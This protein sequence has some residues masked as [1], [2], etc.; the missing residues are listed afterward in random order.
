MLSINFTSDTINIVE[1]KYAGSKVMV[2]K[3]ISIDVP[4]MAIVNGHIKDKDKVVEIIN[5]E[6]LKNPLRNKKAIVIINSPEIKTKETVVPDV[7]RQEIL[8]LLETEIK[9]IISD[10]QE[11]LIDYTIND[12]F[13]KDKIKYHNVTMIAIP[14]SLILEYCDVLNQCKITPQIFD[15]YS[16]VMLKMMQ[17]NYSNSKDKFVQLNAGLYE[18]EIKLSI[19]DSEGNYF[20]KTVLIDDYS[21]AANGLLNMDVINGVNNDV[22]NSKKLL[23]L[24][25]DNINNIIQFQNHQNP[26]NPISIIKT[27]GQCIDIDDINN[28]IALRTGVQTTNIEKPSFLKD[29]S[30]L[31]HIK[32]YCAIGGLIRR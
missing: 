19:Y 4:K 1:G 10:G 29:R 22:E 18:D 20:F 30:N 26:H 6:L 7:K 5:F 25:V 31:N 21:I 3:C 15:I 13:K 14:K 17:N 23:D 11:H 24:Y 9:D 32:Y 12:T 27:Y 28:Q 2:N 8:Q 16:N